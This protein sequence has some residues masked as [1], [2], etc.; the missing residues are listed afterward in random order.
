MGG[1]PGLRG[2]V[3]PLSP[4]PLHR[5]IYLLIRREIEEGNWQPDDIVPS[6]H[7]IAEFYGVARG[8]VTRAIES[9]KQDGFVYI[10]AGQGCVR[11]G[12]GVLVPLAAWSALRRRRPGRDVHSAWPSTLGTS[13][14]SSEGSG[15]S[16]RASIPQ[17]RA[18][19]TSS[20][21]SSVV[22]PVR[23]TS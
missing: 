16:G 6:Q 17:T 13:T 20:A 21:A 14:R 9:L 10:V 11:L 12:S 8:T 15:T 7:E 5:Q 3:N 23:V 22:S 18:C 1:R 19:R 4:V 2:Q